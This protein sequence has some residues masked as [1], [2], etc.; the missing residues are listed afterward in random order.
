MWSEFW[1]C[2]G[3]SKRERLQSIPKRTLAN[4]CT[5]S[6][7]SFDLHDSSL[8]SPL[9][10]AYYKRKQNRNNWMITQSYSAFKNTLKLSEYAGRVS[11]KLAYFLRIS[12]LIRVNS[13][14]NDYDLNYRIC[15]RVCVWSM[16]RCPTARTASQNAEPI[17]PDSFTA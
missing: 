9:Q 5:L 11:S 13:V 6:K 16:V 17:I 2:W 4:Y 15:V 8:K 1:C 14:R 3:N 12:V 10:L 7:V